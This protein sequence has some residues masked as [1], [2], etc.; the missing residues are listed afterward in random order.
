MYFSEILETCTIGWVSICEGGV[1]G[2]RYAPLKTPFSLK[3]FIA[4]MTHPTPGSP[5][6]P[7]RWRPQLPAH[8]DGLHITGS[9]AGRAR[10]KADH[11]RQGTHA[12]T[13]DTLH[14][15]ALD[16]RPPALD[17]SGLCR[18]LEGGQ[19]LYHAYCDSSII[20]IAYYLCSDRDNEFDKV[21]HSCS[22]PP[23]A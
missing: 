4:G 3:N 9:R 2:L 12:R 18:T 23:A 1:G 5:C 22:P 8:P 20:G 7:R 14:R 19:L 13:L 15:S 17:R 10:C 11:A 21:C 6:I 16:T